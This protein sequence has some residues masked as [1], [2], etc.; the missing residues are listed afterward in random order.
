MKRT[1]TLFFYSILCVCFSTI[2]AQEGRYLQEVFANVERT[3]SVIYGLNTTII[4]NPPVAQPLMCDIYEP[5]DDTASERLL[6]LVAPTGNFLPRPLNGGANGTLKDST[7]V[8]VC[9]RLAKMGYVAVSFFYRQGWDALNPSQEVQTA[10][11]LQAAYRGIQDGRTLVRFFRKT[12][13][14]SENPY[15]IDASRIAMAGIGTG[16]YVA[17]GSAYL[18][19]FEKVKLPKFTDFNTGQPYVQE[20]FHGN[21]WGTNETP[22]NMPN[23]VEYNSEIQATVNIG[24]ALGDSSWVDPGDIPA[25]C[26]HTPQDVFAPYDIGIVIVPT[27][28]NTV[29]DGAAGSLAVTRA[30]HEFGNNQIWVDAAY[31]DSYTQAANTLNMGYEGMMPFNRPFA[32]GKFDCA[33]VGIPGLEV[34]LVP[35]ASPWDWYDQAAFIADWDAATGGMPFPGAVINCNNRANNPDMSAEKGRMYVDSIIG[36]TAPRLYAQLQANPAASIVSNIQDDLKSSLNFKLYPNPANRSFVVSVENAKQPIQGIEIYDLA[37]RRVYSMDHIRRH[38][39]TVN[40]NE[41]MLPGVYIVRTAFAAGIITQKL[42][43]QD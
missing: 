17:L 12:Y 18:D 3:D 15:R 36:Y 32:P 13:Q 19:D 37:G 23:H 16:G 25:I 26:F 41:G 33:L 11:L 43:L 2:M 20:E 1:L 31:S 28:G 6:V 34:D 14:E 24:G 10:T 42:I 22:L 7:V 27:T 30:N 39:Y 38:E 5:A 8:E 40:L 35:E 4:V 29:I 9:T 21:I